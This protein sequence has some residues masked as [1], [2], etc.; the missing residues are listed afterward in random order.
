MDIKKALL[1]VEEIENKII[2]FRRDFHKHPEIGFD[3]FRTA[4]II[5]DFLEELGYHVKKNAAISGVIADLKKDFEG[6]TIL[7]RADIDAIEIDELNECDYKSINQGKMHACGHD[8]HPAMLM[9]AAEILAKHKNEIDGNVRLVFQPSEELAFDIDGE[10]TSGGK[11]MVKRE[12]VMDNVSMCFALHVDPMI[13]AGTIVY[14]KKEV[15][16]SFSA[17]N[18]T[19]EG[20]STHISSQNKG[21]DSILMAAEFINQIQRIPLKELDPFDVAVINIGIIKGGTARNT[22]A[23]TT[24][25]LGGFRTYSKD[26]TN[27][28][29]KSIKDKLEGIKRSYGGDYKLEITS[30]NSPAVINDSKANEILARGA[31]HSFDTDC[32]VET[33]NKSMGSEDFAEYSIVAPG[34]LAALGVG[35]KSKGINVYVHNGHFKIDESALVMGSKVFLGIVHEYFSK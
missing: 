21:I 22:V 5:G 20:K 23:S 28:I 29:W 19:L 31:R 3:T 26:V 8:A 13:E 12:N 24:E 32:V 1:E 34:C 7:L 25:L 14:S 11:Y 2:D 9:G 15:T 6:E 18:I 4:E 30:N 16:A 17:F 27:H 33:T 10:R 35:N